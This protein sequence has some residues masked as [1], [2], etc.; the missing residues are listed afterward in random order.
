MGVFVCVG[1]G[2]CVYAV[3]NPHFRLISPND[4]QRLPNR[5]ETVYIKFD[6][7]P[8]PRKLTHRW[9]NTGH[10]V[11]F[12]ANA[13]QRW[14]VSL[15]RICCQ[16]NW[17]KSLNWIVLVQANTIGLSWQTI[18]GTPPDRT[19]QRN[20]TARSFVLPLR[21]FFFFRFTFLFPFFYR[22]FYAC[23]CLRKCGTVSIN[24]HRLSSSCW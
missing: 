15:W 11:N 4:G 16:S 9:S 3:I 8:I 1:V 14:A 7:R 12:H 13:P 22:W 23:S 20:F 21:A 6:A 10:Y 2:E 19:T 18:R 24:M 17:K 5:H